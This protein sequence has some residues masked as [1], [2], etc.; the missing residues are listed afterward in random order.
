MGSLSIKKLANRNIWRRV[1]SRF[2]KGKENLLSSVPES[3]RKGGKGY[4]ENFK[5][6]QIQ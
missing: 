2:A 1:D 5:S 4:E 3:K 6:G